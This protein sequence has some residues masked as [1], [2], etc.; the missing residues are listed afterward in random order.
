MHL[1]ITGYLYGWCWGW[2]NWDTGAEPP[3]HEETW[4]IVCEVVIYLYLYVG[5]TLK[6]QAILMFNILI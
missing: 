6:K 1:L 2:G 3:G 4:G 5:F